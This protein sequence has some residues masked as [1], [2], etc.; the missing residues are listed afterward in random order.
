MK[1]ERET[2]LGLLTALEPGLDAK[3]VIEHASSF[4]FAKGE[5][6]TYNDQVAARVPFVEGLEGAV[7]AEKLLKLVRGMKA[8]E[9]E[10]RLSA[11]KSELLV[12]AGKAS[13]GLTIEPIQ[14][15]WLAAMELPEEKAWKPLPPDFAD[16]VRQCL[17]STAS[18]M[19]KPVL[20]CVHLTPTHIESCDNFRATRRVLAKKGP[21]GNVPASA[22][23]RILDRSPEE[24]AVGSGWI[25]FRLRSTWAEEDRVVLSS[26]L[27]T[28]EAFPDLG[29]IFEV[30]GKSVVL[31]EGV[32]GVVARASVFAQGD[33]S[34]DVKVTV[35]IAPGE[36]M[37]R[38]KGPKGWYKEKEKTDWKGKELRFD[39]H[40][41]LFADMLKILQTITVGDGQLKL[42]GEGLTHILVLSAADP[43]AETGE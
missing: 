7:E 43:T 37:V 14:A 17:F 32:E 23:R 22:M 19:T 12:S 11:D 33:F 24:W 31:P 8:K 20:T 42:E 4:V 40:P 18:D 21:T 30:K 41:V 34:N 28:G 5:I 38:G 16:A 39:V 1:I 26:R 27:F 3:D 15:D 35:T 6:R 9:L 29:P 25:H 36:V 13:A 2:L 10:V